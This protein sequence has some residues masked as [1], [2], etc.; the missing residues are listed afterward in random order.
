MSRKSGC[1]RL[2]FLSNTRYN[3]LWTRVR[4]HSTNTHLV[5]DTSVIRSW[6]QSLFC[7]TS[8]LQWPTRSLDSHQVVRPSWI[9]CLWGILLLGAGTGSTVDLSVSWLQ[10]NH[11]DSFITFYSVIPTYIRGRLTCSTVGLCGVESLLSKYQNQTS[12]G[13]SRNNIYQN[14]WRTKT[15]RFIQ[16]S[17]V[18]HINS[19]WHRTGETITRNNNR[20]ALA[21]DLLRSRINSEVCVK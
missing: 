11:Y 3:V 7:V 21:V 6:T 2:W 15:F 4:G 12:T 8:R 1:C 18:D 16:S 14:P 13:K 10:V 20:T 19:H 5:A 17:R 9:C